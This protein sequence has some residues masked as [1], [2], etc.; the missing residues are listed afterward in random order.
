MNVDELAT[1]HP[2]GPARRR[3]HVGRPDRGFTSRSWLTEEVLEE[4]IRRGIEDRRPQV[5]AQLVNLLGGF[6]HLAL[7]DILQ[8]ATDDIQGCLLGDLGE[9]RA[10]LRLLGDGLL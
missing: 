3:W 6:L 1:A 7:G 10:V 8:R 5:L 2:A 4:R 9:G